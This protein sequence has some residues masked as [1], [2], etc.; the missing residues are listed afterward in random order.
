MILFLLA[1]LF[2]VCFSSPPNVIL[3]MADDLGWADVAPYNPSI[4]YTPN[5]AKLA[6]QGV[7]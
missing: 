2:D 3:I 4:E 6:Q 5:I 1:S 7:R